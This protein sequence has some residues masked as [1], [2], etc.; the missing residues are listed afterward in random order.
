MAGS[1]LEGR[2]E[3]AEPPCALDLSRPKL[4]ITAM[5]A[6]CALRN[7]EVA[8]LM[9]DLDHTV[10]NRRRVCA[11]RKCLE[12]D[13]ATLD[14]AEVFLR[15]AYDALGDTGPLAL[16]VPGDW[17]VQVHDCVEHALLGM[18]DGSCPGARDATMRALRNLDLI[19]AVAAKSRGRRE[20]MLPFVVIRVLVVVFLGAYTVVVV[21]GDLISGP[22]GLKPLL[23]EANGI[24]FAICLLFLAALGLRPAL[25]TKWRRTRRRHLAEARK[26]ASPRMDAGGSGWAQPSPEP[27]ADASP[28]TED[29]EFGRWKP[30]D[31]MLA[32]LDYGPAVRLIVQRAIGYEEPLHRFWTVVEAPGTRSAIRRKRLVVA[33]RSR[34]WIIDHRRFANA[35]TVSH[36]IAYPE[37]TGFEKRVFSHRVHVNIETR[38][39]SVRFRWGSGGALSREQADTLTIILQRRSHLPAPTLRTRKRFSW[40]NLQRAESSTAAKARTRQT[41]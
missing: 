40:T 33:T 23:V 37:I 32:R 31:G 36:T 21:T 13:P 26:R 27:L 39:G 3:L 19:L 2:A 25:R 12:D 35:G 41:G 20:R 34:L 9:L 17:F 8:V 16:G 38:Q 28:A 7:F 1:A 10:E 30:F 6:R 15:E 18:G 29:Y 14:Q 4:I 22:S 11:V 5:P 24:A